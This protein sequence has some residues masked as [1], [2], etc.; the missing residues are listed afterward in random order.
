MYFLHVCSF[1]LNMVSHSEEMPGL[2]K[3][4]NKLRRKSKLEEPVVIYVA[5]SF[6]IGIIHKVS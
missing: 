6:I 4:Q 3:I 2:N 1:A 5:K